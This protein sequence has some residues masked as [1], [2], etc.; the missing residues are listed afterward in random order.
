[1]VVGS[2]CHIFLLHEQGGGIFMKQL[3]LLFLGFVALTAFIGG[4]LLISAPDGHTVRLSIQL[5]SHSPFDDY[6]IPGYVLF[7]VVGGSSLF[8]LISTLRHLK[9]A[10]LFSLAAG[11]IIVVWIL[12]QIFWMRTFYFMQVLYLA[13]GIFI[14]WFAKLERKIML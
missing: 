7:F 13:Q 12:V 9:K 4:A 5:L 8:A 3:F 2:Y 11:G 6:L 14:F 1:M 10:Y